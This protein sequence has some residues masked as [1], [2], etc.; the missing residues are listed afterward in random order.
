MSR[1]PNRGT[2]PTSTAAGVRLGTTRYLY[3]LFFETEPDLV[4]LGDFGWRWRPVYAAV[5]QMFSIGI[6]ACT[7]GISAASPFRST[8]I[9]QIARAPQSENVVSP[10]RRAPGART[11]GK[12][13]E[14][15]SA[16]G[17]VRDVRRWSRG[18]YGPSSALHR[19]YQPISWSGATLSGA[20]SNGVFTSTS[21]PEGLLLYNP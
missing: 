3:A 11:A 19:G 6:Q 4:E 20:L 17:T 1:S 18:R 2:D 7:G 14:K 12:S 16:F 8:P 9:P 21:F 13:K 10:K 15:I 5:G